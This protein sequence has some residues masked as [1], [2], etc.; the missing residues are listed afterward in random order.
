MAGT[1]PTGAP[2]AVAEP[3]GT[4][5]LVVDGLTTEIRR[6]RGAF[7]AVDGVSFSVRRTGRVP[8]AFMT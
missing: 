4:D 6:R 7:A 1:D 3:A 8:S 5:L 2:A